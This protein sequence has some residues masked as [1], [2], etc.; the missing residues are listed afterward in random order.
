MAVLGAT[1][2]T[3]CTS[4]PSFLGGAADSVQSRMV[5]RMATV[6]VSWTK[7]TSVNTG[8]LRVVNGTVS[9]GGSLIWDQV[10]TTRPYSGGIQPATDGCSVGQ[11]P[12]TLSLE[13]TLFSQGNT[14]A[15][16]ITSPEISPHTHPAPVVNPPGSTTLRVAAALGLAQSAQTVTTDGG[17]GG[18]QP[19]L[20][21]VDQHGHPFP[22]TPSHNHTISGA[23]DH[24]FSAGSVDFNLIYVDMVIATKD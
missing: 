17:T 1:S 15:A 2:L 4:I 11:A 13:K 3:G 5:F 6:P 10:F 23:H 21:S 7:D 20:H 14:V 12:L 9:P 24:T 22:A 19:H 16:P 8:S 18:G